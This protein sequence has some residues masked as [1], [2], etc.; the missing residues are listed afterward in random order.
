MTLGKQVL[1]VVYPMRTGEAFFAEV[2]GD[3]VVQFGPYESMEQ[4]RSLVCV[5][6]PRETV[7]ELAVQSTP[8]DDAA[9]MILGNAAVRKTLKA[10][11]E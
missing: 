6:F 3:E 11:N 10:A 4:V 5:L 1:V 8:L 7:V 2:A 9:V